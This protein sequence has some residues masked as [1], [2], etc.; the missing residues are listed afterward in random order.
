[1]KYI[2]LTALARR[3]RRLIVVPLVA[4]LCA[5]ALVGPG[6]M[7]SSSTA[8]AARTTA[9]LNRGTEKHQRRAAARHQPSGAGAILVRIRHVLH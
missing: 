3:P 2:S 6:L 1:M 7:N 8:T 4:L 9:A 5:G